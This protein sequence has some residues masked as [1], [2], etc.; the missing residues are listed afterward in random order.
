MFTVS[1]IAQRI[2]RPE[3]ELAKAVARVRGWTKEGLLHPIGNV[4]TG[5]GNARRYSMDAVVDAVLIETFGQAFGS[6]AVSV[7]KFLKNIRPY[8]LDRKYGDSFLLIGRTPGQIDFDA[9]AYSAAALAKAIKSGKWQT[10]MVLDIHQ[11]IER[12]ALEEK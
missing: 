3:E 1:D 5:T 8:F 12:L 11:L 10:Y 6:Q 2:K 7:P 9:G 4:N